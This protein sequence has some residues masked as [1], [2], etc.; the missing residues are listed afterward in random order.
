MSVELGT[1]P[2]PPCPPHKSIL[3]GRPRPVRADDRTFAPGTLLDTMTGWRPVETLRPGEQVRTLHGMRRIETLTRQPP[4]HSR[5]HWIV[6][7]N[8]LGNTSDLRLNAGQNVVVMDPVCQRLFGVPLV[9]VPVPA[10]TGFRGVRT[11]SGFTLRWG[12]ALTFESEEIVF[13]QAGALLHVPGPESDAHHR[14][15]TY[16]ESSNLLPLLRAGAYRTIRTPAPAPE[17][18]PQ[19]RQ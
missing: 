13:V 6:P 2:A 12:I 5:T 3:S 7:A 14:R 10:T 11:V 8:R 19:A 9:L 17:K 1:E 15:L 16:R 4:D 18:Q